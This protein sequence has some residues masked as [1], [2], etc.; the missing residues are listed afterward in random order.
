MRLNVIACVALLNLA[1]SIAWANEV[2]ITKAM[3]NAAVVGEGRLSVAFWDVYDARLYAPDGKWEP[4][5]TFALSIHYL[6][7]IDGKDIADR[8][9]QEMRA[10]GFSDEV[11][12]A[13]WNAQMKKIFPNVKNGSVISAVFIPGQKTTFYNDKQPIGVIKGAEFTQRF[14]D[15]WLSEKTSEPYLR[16]QLLGLL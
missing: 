6:R 13:A 15:I 9:V 5:K 4:S 8:S 14:F 3:M 2:I 11:K 7:A 12:L 10:Q 1:T 16:K